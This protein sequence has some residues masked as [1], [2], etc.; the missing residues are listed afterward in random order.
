M[1]QLKY[2]EKKNNMTSYADYVNGFN[3]IKH[4]CGVNTY[5]VAKKGTTVFTSKKLSY[6]R[7][8]CKAR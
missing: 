5:Y 3:I 2:K 1:V 8:K 7:N 6:L 4:H